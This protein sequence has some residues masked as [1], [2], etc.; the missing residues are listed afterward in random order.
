MILKSL[1]DN[2]VY[3]DNQG[4][5]IHVFPSIAEF[6]IPD[7][8]LTNNYIGYIYEFMLL[9]D[10]IVFGKLY[11][12]GTWYKGAADGA[13]AGVER[14]HGY[15]REI[16]QSC[17]PRRCP[18]SPHHRF[19][20]HR[21][22]ARHRTFVACGAPRGVRIIGNSGDVGAEGQNGGGDPSPEAS[23]NV[24]RRVGVHDRCGRNA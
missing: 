6:E 18:Q 3:K 9:E 10:T 8:A 24:Q 21:S 19:R 14:S 4:K 11:R 5:T 2:I 22:D 20:V 13:F 16:G 23:R 15:Q 17:R 12:K 1:T 7:E